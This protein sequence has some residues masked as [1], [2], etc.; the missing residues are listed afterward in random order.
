MLGFFFDLAVIGY[1]HSRVRV[2]GVNGA[3][4]EGVG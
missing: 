3:M 4:F 2:S 1:R